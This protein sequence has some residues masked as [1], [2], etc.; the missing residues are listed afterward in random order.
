MVGIIIICHCNLST[1]L[2]NVVKL[3]VGDVKN[4]SAVSV[5]PQESPE[6][7]FKRIS[8]A[9]K[10]V[11]S[12]DGVLMLTDMFGGTP[13]NLSLPF[14]DDAH[15]EVLTGVNLPMLVRLITLREGKKRNLLEL[16]KDL[17][18]YGRRN[19]CIASEIL[20]NKQVSDG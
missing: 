13:S 12:G 10:A 8:K 4:M 11:D 5:D 7:S 6:D 19:I 17:K 14:L 2:L 15:I 20:K 16:A 1:E 18:E 3:I 9:I